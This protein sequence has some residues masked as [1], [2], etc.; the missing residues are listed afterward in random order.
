MIGDYL[1]E[2]LVLLPWGNRE[3]GGGKWGAGCGVWGVGCGEKK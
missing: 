3:V 1:V 2:Y